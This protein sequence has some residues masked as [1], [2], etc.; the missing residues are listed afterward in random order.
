MKI[1]VVLLILLS[2]ELDV[3]AQFETQASAK[4]ERKAL[5]QVKKLRKRLLRGA[6]FSR[7]AKKFSDDPGSGPYGGTL[8]RVQFGQFVPQFDSTVLELEVSEIS[9]PVR[10]DFGYHLIELIA[11][12][13][14]TFTSRHILITP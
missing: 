11:K 4:E 5:R 3:F 10:T 12:D 6:D 13:E 14:T 7:L 9:E 8:G 2:V 1:V